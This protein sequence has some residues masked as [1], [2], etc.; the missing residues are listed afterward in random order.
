MLTVRLPTGIFH[1]DPTQPLGPAGGFGQVFA[2]T[3]V[4]G[5]PVAVKKLHFEAGDAAHRE[6]D[7]ARELQGQKF[8]HVIGF[9]DAG[10]CADSGSYFVVMPRAD[11]SL[12][13][14]LRQIGRVDPMVAADI[15]S[16]IAAGLA[17][18]AALVHRDLKPGNILWHETQW[19][20]ADFGIARFV[21]DATSAR[22]LKKCLSPHYAA[23]EQWRYERATAATD[24]YA[25]GC[26][27]FELLAGKPPFTADPEKEHQSAPLPPLTCTDPRLTS[28]VSLML[29]KAP[30]ARPAV[31]RVQAILREVAAAPV[32]AKPGP[33]SELAEVGAAVA[34]AAQCLE[35]EKE[36]KSRLDRDRNL[37]HDEAQVMLAENVERL[38]RKIHLQ[39]PA[40]ERSD[41]RRNPCNV[42]IRLG[43]AMVEI[44]RI[45]GKMVRME[46]FTHSKWDVVTSSTLTVR[47]GAGPQYSWEVSL[48]FVKRPTD[49]DYRWMEAGYFAPF[50]ART[51]PFSANGYREADLC[52]GPLTSG[53]QFAW[54]PVPIDGEHEDAFHDRCI[55]LFA[56]AAKGQLREPGHLP[57][58]W[59]PQM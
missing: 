13:Q 56:K 24:V 48:W 47:N 57:F 17:E 14:R 19:K 21:E 32:V 36:A 12:A 35:A 2:G 27:A 59:P 11:F 6:L 33:L 50:H 3:T 8:H 20:I 16:Q 18:V 7:I 4:D 51:A 55:W 15:L 9:I 1:Y 37:L 34:S 23:P 58:H 31:S 44:G 5:E 29:R 25:L 30:A 54:G 10:L 42:K 46:E 26:I 53:V 28:I 52:A 40:A 22:T 45:V 49:S 39:V 41:E 38:W 43:P